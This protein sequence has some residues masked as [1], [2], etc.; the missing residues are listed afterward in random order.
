MKADAD[1]F[2]VVVQESRGCV[3]S[4]T[5]EA[6]FMSS[7][8]S[9]RLNG[10]VSV[11]CGSKSHPWRL[12]AAAGQR[13]NISLLDFTADDR[14]RD[15]VTCTRK[16]GYVLEKWNKRNAYVCAGHGRQTHLLVSQSNNLQIVQTPSSS[17]SLEENYLI[18][19]EGLNSS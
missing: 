5:G 16:Y 6:Q 8:S 13:I 17:Q 11:S 15:R 14:P 9:S 3:V 4:V 12:E 7:S 19:I 10:G 2:C 18:S 1:L